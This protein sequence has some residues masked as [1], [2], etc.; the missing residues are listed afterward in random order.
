VRAGDV[1]LAVDGAPPASPDAVAEAA[2]A[3]APGK[4]LRLTLEV[5]GSRRTVRVRGE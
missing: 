3:L 4:E 1:L 5:G 2:R